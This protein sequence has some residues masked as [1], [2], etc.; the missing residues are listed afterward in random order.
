MKILA[1][2]L[3]GPAD[4]LDLLRDAGHEVL[5]GRPLDQPGR[6]AYTEAE[7]IE[8]A[9]HKEFT[10]V[11]LGSRPG[12]RARASQ[13]RL[14]PLRI[15]SMAVIAVALSSA[16][17]GGAIGLIGVVAVGSPSNMPIASLAH[18]SPA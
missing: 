15:L 8:S 6:K 14:R 17:G 7:L 9:R 13:G 12:R 18:L 11:P 5:I 2:G 16:A 4:E 3:S 1:T 10:P